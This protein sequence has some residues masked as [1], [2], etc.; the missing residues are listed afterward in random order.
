MTND[1]SKH[2]YSVP[3]NETEFASNSN[4]ECGGKDSYHS[5]SGIVKTVM[6]VTIIQVES[7]ICHF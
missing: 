3:P 6:I 4:I 7:C 2:I 5:Y 1:L